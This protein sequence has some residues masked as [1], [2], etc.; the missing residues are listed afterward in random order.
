MYGALE[1]TSKPGAVE[2]YG[3]EVVQSFRN[4]LKARPPPMTPDHPNF[5]AH[6]RK[7]VSCSIVLPSFLV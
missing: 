3:E 4:G 1:G 2:K 7:Y 6:E 5:H